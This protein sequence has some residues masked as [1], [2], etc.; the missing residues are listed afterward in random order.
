M[1]N[2]PTPLHMVSLQLD[3]SR[4]FTLA[5]RRR[6]PLHDLDPGYLIHCQL[7]ELFGELAPRLFS[8]ENA[9]SRSWR[10]LAYGPHDADSLR[11]QA[12]AFADPSIHAALDWDG[13]ASKRMPEQWPAGKSMEFRVRAC[14]TV[15]MGRDG[16]HHRKGAEVDAFLSQCW[17]TGDPKVQV[18]REEVYRA[19]LETHFNRLGGVE[20][21]GIQIER[22]S[23][24]R[25]VRRTQGLER[26]AKTLDR[27]DVSFRGELTITDSEGFD[28]LLR[29]GI[30]RHRAFGFGMLLLSPL[31]RNPC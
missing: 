13:F 27:P 10:V 19:W 26:K 6:L 18:D 1:S 3:A 29:R 4:L 31:R 24:Q 7:G 23:L 21:R 2:N 17:A 25:F 12:D 8:L 28:R 30:G 5:R 14:P 22:F 11:E 20:P 16:E 9:E 15:R